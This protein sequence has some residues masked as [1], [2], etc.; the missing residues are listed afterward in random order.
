MKPYMVSYE[1]RI[2][3]IETIVKKTHEA[4]IESYESLTVMAIYQL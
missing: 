2:N 4:L 1:I 3:S